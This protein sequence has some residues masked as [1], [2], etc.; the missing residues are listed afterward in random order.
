MNDVLIRLENVSKSY[1]SGTEPAVRNLTLE[2]IRG[3]VLVLVGPSGC[4]KSTTLRLINR[5]IEPTSGSMFIDGED[6]TKVNPSELRRKIG[7][8]IQQVGLF[9]HRTIAENI[10]T[11]PQLL[12][13]SKEKVNARIDELLELVS[14][15][16]ET[17]RDRYPKELS[18]GQAQR[19]GVARALAAD[20]DILLMD[21]PFGAIDPITRDRLQNE[22]LRLQKEV[23]KTI[24]FVTHDIDEAIKMGN[25]IAILREG[26]EIAQLD[27]PEAILAHPADEFVESFLGSGAILKGLTLRKVSDIELHQVPTLTSP[28]LREEALKTLQDS[29][30]KVALLLD[31]NNRPLRWIDERALNRTSQPIEKSGRPVTVDLQPEDTLQDALTVMLQSSVGMACVTDRKGKYL[32]CT[33]IESLAKLIM[34]D[35][36]E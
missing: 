19:I 11:V 20:P 28:V 26:S 32:G 1:G 35:G 15:D 18:G 22:F 5:L 24:V 36:K 23:K 25:R 21:E 29:P 17:Y 10:A 2:V 27:T 14:M 31:G 16:P 6:V 7:Y 4:G 13:W 8:V 12:G 33:T 34:S 9:P 30:D 3:E